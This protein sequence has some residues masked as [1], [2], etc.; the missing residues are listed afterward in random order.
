[1]A[2]KL[3]MIE[4]GPAIILQQQAELEVLA[5]QAAQLGSQAQPLPTHVDF[6]S[7]LSEL[8]EEEDVTLVTLPTERREM[9]QGYPIAEI[10]F[11]LS[12]SFQDILRV[13]YQIEK[14]DKVGTLSRCKLEKQL[15]QTGLE[16]KA[17]LIAEVEMRRLLQER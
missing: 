14:T 9:L 2:K 16:R 13:I 17:F 3:A 5:R 11:S 12:G 15:V 6:V 8:A 10:N 7:Y 4:T 1:M